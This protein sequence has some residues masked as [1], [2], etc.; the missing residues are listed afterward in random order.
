MNLIDE[1]KKRGFS[2]QIED[3][4]AKLRGSL[5]DSVSSGK[6]YRKGHVMRQGKRICKTL[7]PYAI[8]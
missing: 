1:E 4:G 2:E 3:P 5:Q 6:E 8:C 7:T